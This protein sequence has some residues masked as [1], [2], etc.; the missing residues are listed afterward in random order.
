MC[1]AITISAAILDLCLRK[2]RADKSPDYRDVIVF[3]KLRFQNVF[4]PHENTKLLRFQE[5]FRK[6]P[7]SVDVFSGLVWTEGL[8]GEIKLKFKWGLRVKWILDCMKTFLY[9]DLTS[10]KH[11]YP[12][13][14]FI[15][16]SLFILL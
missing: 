6:A 5:R 10:P 11:F 3:E 12:I 2:T 8:T 7:F 1:I 14:V 9:M 4:R 13:N 16:F 15:I